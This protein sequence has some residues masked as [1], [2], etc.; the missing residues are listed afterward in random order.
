MS[1][2]AARSLSNFGVGTRFLGRLG[3]RRQNWVSLGA[4]I[5][6]MAHMATVNTAAATTTAVVNTAVDT[7][8][9][10]SSIVAALARTTSA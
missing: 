4:V 10:I 6:S 7:A 2:C 3:K 9:H 1:G 5:A 8:V